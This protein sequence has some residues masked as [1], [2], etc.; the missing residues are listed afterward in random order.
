MGEWIEVRNG[1]TPK[2]GDEMLCMDPDTNLVFDLIIVTRKMAA[3]WTWLDY[4]EDW[5]FWFRPLNAPKE[6]IPG[7]SDSGVADTEL[8]VRVSDGSFEG[9]LT[10]PVDSTNEQRVGF[11][12]MW[13]DMLANACQV[14]PIDS[15]R[16]ERES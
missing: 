1:S 13:I 4:R 9:R 14:I 3:E 5:W 15:D 10:V 8:S 6:A 12:K 2:A 16:R 11:A 7:F